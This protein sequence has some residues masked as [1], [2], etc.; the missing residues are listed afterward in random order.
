MLRLPLMF[1]D[2]WVLAFLTFL[3]RDAD[4]GRKSEELMQACADGS[5]GNLITSET[6][7]G[8]L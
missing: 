7:A 8:A 4:L 5:Y 3:E 6:C 2:A 1:D